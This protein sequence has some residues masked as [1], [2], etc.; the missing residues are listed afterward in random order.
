M[1]WW[2]VV[3]VLR[4]P[5]NIM[6][7]QVVVWYTTNFVHLFVFTRSSLRTDPRISCNLSLLA[8]GSPPPLIKSPLSVCLPIYIYYLLLPRSL[9]VARIQAA[10]ARLVALTF[11]DGQALCV[12][13]H[14][15]FHRQSGHCVAVEMRDGVSS[16]RPQ[17]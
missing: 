13:H 14:A 11:R 1:T 16:V 7:K 5:H 9:V 10:A 17:T 3:N 6:Y 2:V 12:S 15:E 8:I 4:E